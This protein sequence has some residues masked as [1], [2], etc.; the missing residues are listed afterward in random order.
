MSHGKEAPKYQ[1]PECRATA[2]KRG[3]RHKRDCSLGGLQRASDEWVRNQ[4]EGASRDR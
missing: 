2:G 4:M 1:C 3:I